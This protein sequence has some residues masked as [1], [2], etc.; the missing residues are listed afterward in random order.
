MSQKSIGELKNILKDA[1]E[2]GLISQKALAIID[3][4]DTVLAGMTGMDIDEIQATEVI[5]MTFIYDDSG[6]IRFAKLAEPVRQ[7]QNAM[8][9]SIINSKQKDN[10]MI[11][12]WKLGSDAE[13][14]HSYIPA[15]QAVKLDRNNYDPQSGTALYDTWIEA[16]AANVAYAQKLRATG[17]PVKNIVAIITD[18]MDERSRKYRIEDCK[19][20]NTDLLL[21]EQFILAFVG[22]GNDAG[23]ETRFR[24]IAEDMGFPDGAVLTAEATASEMRKVFNVI[25]QSAI[26][27]SQKAVSATAQ[28][29]FFN[30]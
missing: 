22:V 19:K 20:I 30:P 17:T 14:V 4:N 1:A 10:I 23:D 21:S 12:Q 24:M 25:S 28:N 8:I 9:D 11:A 6:S 16:L 18:G 2:A 5:L 29:S 13:L 3:V 26:R 27:A 15:D 7:G